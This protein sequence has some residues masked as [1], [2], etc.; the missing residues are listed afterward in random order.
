MRCWHSRRETCN[1]G[2]YVQSMYICTD[3]YICIDVHMYICTE[4]EWEGETNDRFILIF[5]N[6]H[7]VTVYIDETLPYIY[8]WI[9]AN[10]LEILWSCTKLLGYGIWNTT[11]DYPDSKIH[12][13]N[14]GPTWVLSAPG[15]PHVGPINLA[16]RVGKTILSSFSSVRLMGEWPTV[17]HWFMFLVGDKAVGLYS[18][19]GWTPYRKISWSPKAMRLDVLMIVLI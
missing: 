6:V 7:S 18:L 19:S 5:W 1:Y 8:F 13:A 17:D 4:L 15:G 11:N 9:F 3:M 12:G 14:M 10:A 2:T 16:I